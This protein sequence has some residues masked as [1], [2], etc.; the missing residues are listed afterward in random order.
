MQTDFDLFKTFGVLDF[1]VL[2]VD[3]I[4]GVCVG[5][6]TDM[7]C[8]LFWYPSFWKRKSR[9]MQRETV[10]YYQFHLYFP[11]FDMLNMMFLYTFINTA[12]AA[13]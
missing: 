1:N 9:V 3:C 10:G 12:S 8:N 11:L 7:V 5:R 6:E 2:P 4:F 13:E